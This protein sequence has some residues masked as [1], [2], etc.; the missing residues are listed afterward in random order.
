MEDPT[1]VVDPMAGVEEAG[2]LK[3][4]PVAAPEYF[5]NRRSWPRWLIRLCC[6]Y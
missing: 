4:A 3:A 5:V 1:A 6:Y 2:G